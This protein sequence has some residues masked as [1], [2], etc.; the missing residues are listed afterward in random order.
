M[1]FYRF[2]IHGSGKIKAMGSAASGFYTTRWAFAPNEA[3]AGAKAIRIVRREWLSGE[4][5][6]LCE[7]GAPTMTIDIA[8]RIG[9]HQILSAPNK[10]Y[11]FYSGGTR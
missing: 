6:D 4:Y 5:K 7:G 9:M 10:G 2:V 11:T 3:L 1:P 8:T